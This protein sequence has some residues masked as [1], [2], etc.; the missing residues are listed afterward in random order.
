MTSNQR[1]VKSWVAILLTTDEVSFGKFNCDVNSKFV[2]FESC[3]LRRE[4][5]IYFHLPSHRRIIKHCCA[6]PWQ[7]SSQ[8]FYTHLI[9]RSIPWIQLPKSSSEQYRLQATTGSPPLFRN[10]QQIA[11]PLTCVFIIF[12]YWWKG[13]HYVTL[14]YFTP[15]LQ[16]VNNSYL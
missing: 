10:A 5:T 11:I 4:G 15:M 14:I 2:V 6:F 16:K 8:Y 1:L 3:Y 7:H 13:Y 12:F 9:L